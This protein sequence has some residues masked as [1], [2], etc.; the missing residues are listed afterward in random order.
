MYKFVYIIPLSI[1]INYHL[2]NIKPTVLLFS[3][4]NATS[5]FKLIFNVLNNQFILNF[6]IYNSS[7]N[8]FENKLLVFKQY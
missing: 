3:V 8:Y 4:F 6:I 5:L 7:N 1:F 2:F